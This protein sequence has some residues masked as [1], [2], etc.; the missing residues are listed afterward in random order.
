[1][2][3]RF[4]AALLIAPVALIQLGAAAQQIPYLSELLSRGEAFYKLYNEKRRAGASLSAIEPIRKR[5]EEA[6]RR[7]NIPGLI[8]LMSEGT[9]VLQ[10][11]PWDD[12]QKFLASLTV[13]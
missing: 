5:G 9:N 13:E 8:E 10:G 2:K 11:K 1:M 4:V 12:K 3:K 7:G 6:F